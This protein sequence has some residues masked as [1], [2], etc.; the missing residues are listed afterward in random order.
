MGISNRPASL[1]ASCFSPQLSILEFRMI[2]HLSVVRNAINDITTSRNFFSL[3]SHCFIKIYFRCFIGSQ[4]PGFLVFQY[5]IEQ[6]PSLQM[7]TAIDQPDNRGRNIGIGH[8]YFGIVHREI[9]HIHR[10]NINGSIR[11]DRYFRLLF[12]TGIR[13][14]N[15]FCNR[16]YFWSFAHRQ[17]PKEPVLIIREVVVSLF[18][19]FNS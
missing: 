19:Y 8:F 18:S 3:D 9:T 10:R 1:L 5:S 11:I 4:S 7:R 12:V 16:F 6:G 17:N 14:C 2:V 13:R 15:F